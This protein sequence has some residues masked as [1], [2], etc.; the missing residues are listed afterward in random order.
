MSISATKCAT[1]RIVT[2]KDS[3]YLADPGLALHSAEGISYADADTTIKYLGVRISPWARIDIKSLKRDLCTTL[4]RIKKLALKPH[5]KATRPG[6]AS[7]DQRHLPQSTADG[8]I[9]CG[10]RDGGGFLK[11]EFLVVSSGLR[12]GLKF[13]ESPDQ[14]MR[15]LADAAGMVNRLKSL[16]ASAQINWPITTEGIRHFKINAKKKELASWSA[17]VSQGK[18]VKSCTDD[19]IGMHGCTILRS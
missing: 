16:A 5:Q 15:A 4:Q 3:W 11:L 1:F 10:K 7:S 19:R 6:A 18:S 2:T 17:L 12:A 14:V 8:F 13:I 9:Y